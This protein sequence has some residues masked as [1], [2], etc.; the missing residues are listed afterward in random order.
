[1]RRFTVIVLIAL[2]V[3]GLGVTT[4][5]AQGDPLRDEEPKDAPGVMAWLQDDSGLVQSGYPFQT[6]T[7]TTIDIDA[8]RLLGE[9]HPPT[10][11]GAVVRL[12]PTDRHPGGSDRHP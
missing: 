2:L 5:L 11:G 9:L 1:M 8:D 7:G 6:I 3:V 10:G 4:S 12:R